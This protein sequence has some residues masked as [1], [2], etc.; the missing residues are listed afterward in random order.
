MGNP[1][2]PHDVYK[3]DIDNQ[4]AECEGLIVNNKVVVKDRQSHIADVAA[5]TLIQTSKTGV[6]TTLS[7]NTGITRA[8]FTL[9][10]SG[11][12]SG[13]TSAVFTIPARS[14]L[15]NVEVEV[16]AAF[17]GD[18]TK[19]M[20]VGTAANPDAYIDE[21]DFDP[22][23]GAQLRSNISGSTN[24]IKVPE[25]NAA[26]VDV[27][28]LWTNTANMGAGSVLVTAHYII[29]T[30]TGLDDLDTQLAAFAVDATGFDTAMGQFIVDLDAHQAKVNALYVV[31]E[32]LGLLA[33]S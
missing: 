30:D 18:T 2:L 7:S 23:T 32:D 10:A 24:D 17:D 16:L 29:L 11:G 5:T 4:Y 1:T 15:L 28:T 12:G 25:Y 6:A 27:K 22:S 13:V 14:L 33:D 31:L 8:T 3:Q 9:D 26:A 21:S 19:K 20:E